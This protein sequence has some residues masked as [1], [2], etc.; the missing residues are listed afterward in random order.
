MHTMSKEENH[1]FTI[2]HGDSIHEINLIKEVMDLS[3]DNCK[4]LLK[5]IKKTQRNEKIFPIHGSEELTLSK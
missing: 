1:P 2:V 3:K 5:E 4:T